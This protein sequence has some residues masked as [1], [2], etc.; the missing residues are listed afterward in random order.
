MFLRVVPLAMILVLAASEA[1][2]APISMVPMPPSKPHPAR[3][4][5]YSSKTIFRHRSAPHRS[6]PAQPTTSAPMSSASR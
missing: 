3:H 2:A 6:S 5:G 4:R 1:L